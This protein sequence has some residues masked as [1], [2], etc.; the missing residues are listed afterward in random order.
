[1]AQQVSYIATESVAGSLH[2][3]FPPLR[4]A[5]ALDA[6]AHP[7]LEELHD[8][9]HAAAADPR[10]TGGKCVFFKIPEPHPTCIPRPRQLGYSCTKPL[11][12]RQRCQE[13]NH[14][15]MP[16]CGWDLLFLDPWVWVPRDPPPWE[17]WVPRTTTCPTLLDGALINPVHFFFRWVWSGGILGIYE[18]RVCV[19]ARSLHSHIALFY[20]DSD[21]SR[22][23]RIIIG[24]KI[25]I[26]QMLIR[27][28]RGKWFDKQCRN[29][30]QLNAATMALKPENPQI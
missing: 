3:S 13:R 30:K 24:Y 6:L 25:D 23:L 2:P 11:K 18:L 12:H 9:A 20:S 28:R 5:P 7:F 17:G 26:Y 4:K 14:D 8:L 29:P 15:S 16:H 19:W 1:M 27:I 21:D 22:H 10:R